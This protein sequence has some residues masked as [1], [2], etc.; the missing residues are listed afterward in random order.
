[1]RS[2]GWACVA[3]ALL[4]AA[5]GCLPESGPADPPP[6]T[7]SDLNRAAIITVIEDVYLREGRQRIIFCDDAVYV[8]AQV[9]ATLENRLGVK[10]EPDSDANRDNSDL[11]PLTPASAETGEIGISISV[12][13]FT[14]DADGRLHVTVTF[15]RSGLDAGAFNYVLSFTDAGWVIESLEPAGVA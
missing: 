15:A 11:P 12:G 9:T 7:A 1:M 13:E 2:S 14:T 5:I 4:A 6:Q 3:G 8:D 10:V